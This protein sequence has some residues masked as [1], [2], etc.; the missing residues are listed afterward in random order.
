MMINCSDFIFFRRGADFFVYDK[1]SAHLFSIDHLHYSI[2]KTIQS[3]KGGEEVIDVLRLGEDMSGYAGDFLDHYRF[4]LGLF[5]RKNQKTS[6]AVTFSKQDILNSLAIVPHIVIEVTERCNFRC[7]YCYYGEMYDSICK[8]ERNHDMSKGD[9]LG[10]LQWLLENKDL[11]H[12]TTLSVS[13]YG[14][15]P[16][17]NIELIKEIVSFCKTEFPEIDFQFRATTNGSLL[18]NHI[19]FLVE[20]DFHLL[21]SMDGDEHSNMHRRF[22]NGLPAFSSVKDNIDFVFKEY[23]EYFL[24]NVDFI[25]VL[26]R[27]SDIVSICRFFSSYGKT[28]RLTT[29]CPEGVVADRKIVAPYEGVSSKEMNTL[30]NINRKVYDLVKNA[31]QRKMPV[32]R[33]ILTNKTTCVRG[34]YIFASKIFM[35]SDKCLYL[36][37]KSS[38]QFPFG[39]FINGKEH[40]FLDE[41]NRYYSEIDRVVKTDCVNCSLHFLCNKC[42]FEGPSQMIPPMRCKENDEELEQRLIT[43]LDYE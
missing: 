9:C 3:S 5:K 32:N 34:C 16:F 11:L 41:I 35:A 29:L 31:S 43:S 40:F 42:F 7:N 25:S 30:Y 21:V 18:R 17:L 33:F 2:G 27:D 14:G 38:R 39:T 24:R 4:I 15:E 12:S 19:K 28:P 10:F 36:C 37:E 23:R 22:K 6:A 13:F 20:N 8:S 26:H 1:R